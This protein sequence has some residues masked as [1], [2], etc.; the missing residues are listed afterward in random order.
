MTYCLGWKSG[1]YIYLIADAVVTSS[2]R[3][4]TAR[5]SFGELHT[6][7]PSRNVEET[8]LK[9]INTT[10]A[11]FSFAGSTKVGYSFIDSFESASRAGQPVREAFR[12]AIVSNTPF[13]QGF[14]VSMLCAFSEKGS[15][16]LTSFNADNDL[17]CVEHKDGDIVQLGSLMGGVI[18]QLSE[19]YIKKIGQVHLDGEFMLTCAMALCQSYGLRANL[20]QFG[21]GGSFSGGFLDE[22]GF[23][24]QPD[25]GYQVYA[26]GGNVPMSTSEGVS[27]IVRDDVLVVRSTL[28]D[29]P[30]RL[31]SHAKGESL[32]S[33]RNRAKKADDECLELLRAQQLEY[34]V[35]LNSHFPI[36]AVIQMNRK[37][38]H[39]NVVLHP[40]GTPSTSGRATF[41]ASVS[42][43][44][45]AILAGSE[46]LLKELRPPEDKVTL[47][48][49]LHYESYLHPRFDIRHAGFQVDFYHPQSNEL[50]LPPETLATYDAAKDTTEI[51]IQNRDG[52]AFS[53]AHL[54]SFFLEKKGGE[55]KDFIP[56]EAKL[57]EG[58]VVIIEFPINFTE[59]S[60]HMVTRNGPVDIK[61]ITLYI[62]FTWLVTDNTRP[63]VGF[64]NTGPV[65]SGF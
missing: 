50:E 35:F 23:H 16:C 11:A 18:E 31:F 5:T 26:A 3:P 44:L 21:V 45:H 48:L 17:R 4:R 63:V 30:P 14:S 55:L 54:L 9:I 34:L 27:A 29:G 28:A 56:E 40:L 38:E 42:P 62:E 24:W 52:M 47:G 43:S 36:V 32:D 59:N 61:N 37:I 53:A 7:S 33:I 2:V 51:F 65:G 19:E 20:I 6:E 58:N 25:I 10:N 57:S 8:A 15:Q 41:T 49:I 46:A 39:R 60:F 1:R 13:Q 22:A 12:T 64:C